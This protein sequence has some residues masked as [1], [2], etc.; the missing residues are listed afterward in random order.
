[1]S[2]DPH[3]ALDE[4]PLIGAWLDQHEIPF[5]QDTAMLAFQARNG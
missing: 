3:I 4:L 5:E 1:M 2:D